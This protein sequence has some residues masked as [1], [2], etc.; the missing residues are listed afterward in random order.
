MPLGN[1]RKTPT[2]YVGTIPVGS[3]HPIAIQSMTNTV[4][5]NIEDTIKQIKSL[6]DAGSELVRITV[7]DA[8]AAKAVPEI[9]KKLRNE[10]YTTP[11][12]GDFH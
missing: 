2:V 3:H 1:K 7:N 5:S 11:I 6:S 8:S 10:G 4:T 9:I 12:V